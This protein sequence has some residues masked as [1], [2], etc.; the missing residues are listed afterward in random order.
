[1]ADIK[2]KND[3]GLMSFMFNL[4]QTHSHE[5]INGSVVLEQEDL[6][7]FVDEK[8]EKRIKTKDISELIADIGVGCLYVSYKL[9]EDE[10]IHFLCRADSKLSKHVSKR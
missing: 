2:N 5:H 10:S 4:K 7:V 3:K 9:K 6:I 8:E 1:M